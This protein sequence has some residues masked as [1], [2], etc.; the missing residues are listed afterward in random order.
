MGFGEFFYSGVVMHGNLTVMVD[1]AQAGRDILQLETL[2]L[3][4]LDFGRFTPS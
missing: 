1:F 4:M 3:L 2:M